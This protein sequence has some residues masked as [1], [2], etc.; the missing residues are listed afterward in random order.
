VH[1][2]ELALSNA[3]AIEAAAQ[4]RLKRGVGTVIEVAQATQNRA[5]ANL[6]DVQAKGAQSD[7]YLSL[8]SAMG[9]S[10]LSTL[11]VDELPPRTLSPALDEP[12]EQIVKDTI[13]SR[14]DIQGAYALAQASEAKIRAA[15]ASFMPKVFVAA[16]AGYGS[17]SAGL[18]T[19]LPFI[20]QLPSVNLSN[21]HYG[22]NI[23][24][25]VTIPL[26]DG[27][28]RAAVLKQ[29]RNDEDS[30]LTKLD[31]TQEEAVRQIVTAQNAVHTSL[32]SQSAAKALLDAAQTTYD[33]SFDAYNHGVG[34]I[35][36]AL[37]AQSGLLTAQDAY[38]DSY[39]AA[40]SAAATLALATGKIGRG[41]NAGGTF[42]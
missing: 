6:A 40:L 22:G 25:G 34:S 37:R 28:M 23:F 5:Q 24:I 26:Y 39:S 16:S 38:T 35:T 41:P 17:G 10:P 21:S 13:A 42:D 20:G 14:P 29:A 30:A 36:D 9:V 2:V 1:S 4:A 18:T 3:E 33:A 15:Q 27:G 7:T 31:R 19:S 32:A 8:L 12:V 11:K